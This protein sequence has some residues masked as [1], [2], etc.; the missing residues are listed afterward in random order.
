MATKRLI[1]NVEL[2]ADE[3]PTVKRPVTWTRTQKKIIPLKKPTDLPNRKLTFD[4]G[5]KNDGLFRPY[6]T[7]LNLRVRKGYKD[8][9][10]VFQRGT[11]PN[12]AY[13]EHTQQDQINAGAGGPQVDAQPARAAGHSVRWINGTGFKIIKNVEVKPDGNTNLEDTPT[14]TRL[15]FEQW[16]NYLHRYSK[17]EKENKVIRDRYIVD[18][19]LLKHSNPHV[20]G[21]S[22]DR[23]TYRTGAARGEV[24]TPLPLDAEQI[25]MIEFERR[26]HWLEDANGW[27]NIRIPLPGYFFN[28]KDFIHGLANF[29]VG[30]ELNTPKFCL[31]G[32]RTSLNGLGDVINDVHYEIDEQ[33]TH[34]EIKY[35]TQTREEMKQFEADNYNPGQL[36]QIPV[37]FRAKT[38]ATEAFRVTNEAGGRVL[39][40][41]NNINQKFPNHG[42][43]TF[44]LQEDMM[45][46]TGPDREP[47]VMT[48]Q[49]ITL[50][51]FELDDD[52]V[53]DKKD[54]G[55][56]D[57]DNQQMKYLWELQC[58]SVKKESSDERQHPQD[59]EPHDLE[60]QLQYGYFDVTPNG[61]DGFEFAADKVD[62]RFK[63]TVWADTLLNR[64]GPVPDPL[65][66]I[67]LV[68]TWF[69]VD[70]L[71]LQNAIDNAWDPPQEYPNTTVVIEKINTLRNGKE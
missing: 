50:V 59:I 31:M 70:L 43:F 38:Y 30:V 11:D 37:A 60:H 58:D 4:V 45:G 42:F 20:C 63:A 69:N 67:H 7:V 32:R 36:R 17:E 71:V 51:R 14:D 19:R 8:G 35:L 66:Y 13:H 56:D 52:R 5:H 54:L 39:N 46:R 53:W 33:G 47:F 55:W 57:R 27:T 10:G 2:T 64:D 26:Q 24:A 28:T 21:I 68:I 62:K 16:R 6:E 48:H 3:Q 49:Y 12:V 29:E 22:M 18:E 23:A 9:N 61:V 65:D 44:I 25:E 40:D 1:E 41:N 15:S 34:L